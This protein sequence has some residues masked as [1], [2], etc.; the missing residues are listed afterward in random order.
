VIVP[1]ENRILNPAAKWIGYDYNSPPYPAPQPA[2]TYD[3]E[4]DVDQDAASFGVVDDTCDVLIAATLA[5]PATSPTANARIFAGPPDFAPDRRPF[6]SIADDL[7]DRDPKSLAK[8]LGK[9]TPAEWHDAVADLFRRTAETASLFDLE[10]ARLRQITINKLRKYEN[11][12]DYPQIDDRTMTATDTIGAEGKPLLSYGAVENTLPPAGDGA[13]GA[14]ALPRSEYAKIR[15]DQ[16]S[17][18]E[19]LLPLLLEN[20]QRAREIMRPPFARVSELK[21][22]ADLQKPTEFRDPR[23][24][25]SYAFDMRMPPYMRDCDYSA[26][27]ISR[28]QWDLLFPDTKQPG[29]PES[30]EFTKSAYRELSASRR[31]RQLKPRKKRPG[32]RP[33]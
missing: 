15:H 11:R 16:L 21:A 4:T 18:P 33:E 20:S 13:D 6:C 22:A 31:A 12:P 24:R 7:A 8:E 30:T 23:F 9:A 1:P 19:L 2:D 3:G 27:S 29:T 32:A 28:L 17:E 26:L 5:A 10:R 14:P 25:R